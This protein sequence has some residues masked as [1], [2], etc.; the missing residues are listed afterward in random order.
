MLPINRTPGPV[1]TP[2]TRGTTP[3][4]ARPADTQEVVSSDDFN[5][6]QETT[7][8]Q[9]LREAMSARAAQGA[10][11]GADFAK[12]AH[13]P[14]S[15]ATGSAV[16][17]AA[18]PLGWALAGIIGGVDGGGQIGAKLGEKGGAAIG[19]ASADPV[20]KHFQT[21]PEKQEE[22]REG[23]KNLGEA[24]GSFIGRVGG[25]ITGGVTGA[26]NPV[27]MGYGAYRVGEQLNPML[28]NPALEGLGRAGGAA[29]GAVE[30]GYNKV[31][32]FFTDRG[33][34]PLPKPPV[35]VNGDDWNISG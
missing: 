15:I 2:P 29:F 26:T 3:P 27:A 25:A 14:L 22:V 9:T 12:R 20:M 11:I 13:V 6:T 1:F 16:A 21:P 4:Q 18:G 30:H 23:I 10:Q 32:D 35:Q 19:K 33:K 28:L 17:C 24:G 34:A 7:R 5:A 31:V 8:P